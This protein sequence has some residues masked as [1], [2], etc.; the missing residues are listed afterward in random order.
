MNP[1]PFEFKGVV[2]LT[3][4]GTIYLGFDHHIY[5]GVALARTLW[6]QGHPAQAVQRARQTVQDAARMDHPATLAIALAWALTVLVWAGDFD[7]AEEHS[8]W[9]V[10]H[11]E[12]H[13]LAPYRALGRGFKGE[14]AIC[15]G[16]ARGGVEALRQIRSSPRH[17]ATPVLMLTGRLS[18]QDEEIA[19][20]AGADEYL[21]K[22]FDPTELLVVAERLIA[23]SLSRRAAC[24]RT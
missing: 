20:R 14:L 24:A 10:S 16:D 21:R 13:S 11:A 15:R 3:R 18:H 17:F 19:L 22:P 4:T 7:A 6:L 23:R 8:D 5:A 2:R 1:L 12:S 9:F